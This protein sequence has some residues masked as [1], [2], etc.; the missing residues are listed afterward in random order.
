ME[1][2]EDIRYWFQEDGNN[3][4]NDYVQAGWTV[5]FLMPQR[6]AV[7][8]R[9]CEIT[10][11]SFCFVKMIIDSVRQRF[12]EEYGMSFYRASFDNKAEFIGTWMGEWCEVA[13]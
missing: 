13:H 9:I 8:S 12:F 3:M 5:C 11:L 1:L 6:K 7:P 2:V 4:K 10:G